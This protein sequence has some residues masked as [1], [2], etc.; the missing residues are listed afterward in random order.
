M[1]H[2][3]SVAFVR[4]DGSVQAH[5]SHWGA[6]E[7][8][9]AF[10]DDP[11]TA[12]RPFGTEKPTPDYADLLQECIEECPD[13]DA[14]PLT[15]GVDGDVYSEAEGVHANL[16]E[17]ATEGLDFLHHEA[18]YVVDTRGEEWTVRA[19]DTV[20]YRSEEPHVGDHTGILV[21]IKTA[22]EWSGFAHDDDAPDASTDDRPQWV[23]DYLQ[24]LGSEASRVPVFSPL[25][26]DN[27]SDS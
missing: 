1:G 5:Y 2:R 16:Y 13:E 11:I 14:I 20:W 23:A 6:L 18:A 12:D 27:R 3:A 15:E 17:W 22:D 4:S 21:E 25:P 19:F 26:A 10:G 24:Y 9:L 8:R 7:A